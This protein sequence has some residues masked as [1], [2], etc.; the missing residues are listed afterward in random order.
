[1]SARH[2]AHDEEAEAMAR[3]RAEALVRASEPPAARPQP[4]DGGPAD[5]ATRSERWA[6]RPY[7]RTRHPR[8][9]R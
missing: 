9:L 2:E 6:S 5:G 7:T 4:A 3:K 8:P 1:M